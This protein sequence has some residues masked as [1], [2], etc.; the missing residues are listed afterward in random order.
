MTRL[1]STLTFT[2]AALV[3]AIAAGAF[4]LSF[5][6]LFITGIQHGIPA[7]K[8]WVWPLL[9]DGPLVVFTLALLVAQLTRQS[10]KLWA[11]LVGTYTLATVIFNLAHA[12]ASLLGWLVAIVAPVG[13]LLTTEALRH[14]ARTVMERQVAVETRAEL[15]IAIDAARAELDTL[16]RQIDAKEQNLRRLN[17]AIAQAKLATNG[18]QQPKVAGFVPGDLV[19]LDKANQAKNHKVVT[20]RQQVLALHRA[21]YD[22]AAI[23]GELEVSLRTV[24]RDIKALNG[25]VPQ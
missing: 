11:G 9:I 6:A 1:I 19:A 21:G 4:T 20:R 2:V 15:D 13:L 5:D 8:G 24:T 22:K 3:F 14:Q 17:D 12:Q 16:T 7:G 23:A 25:H 18:S 10:I